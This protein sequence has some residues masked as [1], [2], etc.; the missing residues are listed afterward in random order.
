MWGKPVNA[1]SETLNES[2]KLENKI[3]KLIEF[4]KGRTNI[5]QEI[6]YPRKPIDTTRGKQ[7]DDKKPQ[8]DACPK[9]VPLESHNLES[10]VDLL[11]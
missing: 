1:T 6:M 3:E 7:W 8:T 2:D 9:L 5:N 11:H 10:K 4:L